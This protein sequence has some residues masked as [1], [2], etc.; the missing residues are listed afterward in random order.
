MKHG[1][2]TLRSFG[3]WKNMPIKILMV[4]FYTDNEH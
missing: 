3:S 1:Y 4:G 2:Q